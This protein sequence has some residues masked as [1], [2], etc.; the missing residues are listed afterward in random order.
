MRM[1]MCQRF[2]V[3]SQ[4]SL[5]PIL[6]DSLSEHF[7]LH[8]CSYCLSPPQLLPP[9][10][11]ALV[12]CPAMGQTAPCH[13]AWCA[14]DQLSCFSLADSLVCRVSSPH[15]SPQTPVRQ[16]GG[17][18]NGIFGFGSWDQDPGDV[19]GSVAVPGVWHWCVAVPSVSLGDFGSHPIFTLRIPALDIPGTWLVK[20]PVS[21]SLPTQIILWIQTLFRVQGVTWCKRR[22][23]NGIVDF[24]VRYTLLWCRSQI[25][26]GENYPVLQTSHSIW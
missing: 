25:T 22:A 9:F 7:S 11:K 26:R 1:G 4:S 13:S 14:T 23:K 16:E 5:I 3:H 21:W 10:P 8:W 17:C 19:R 18:S 20:S 15:P 2:G 12:C 24:V 6:T